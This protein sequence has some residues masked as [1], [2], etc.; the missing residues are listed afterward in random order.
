M[1]VAIAMW[2]FRRPWTINWLKLSRW[3]FSGFLLGG[4]C[5]SLRFE[6]GFWTATA[7][8]TTELS[9]RVRAYSPEKHTCPTDDTG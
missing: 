2:T 7:E 5:T 6:Q 9:I 4:F 8:A 3:L 1:A